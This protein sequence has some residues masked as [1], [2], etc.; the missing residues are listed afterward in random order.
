MSDALLVL[1][2]GSSSLKFSVFL[3]QDLPQPVVRGQIEGLTA[4]PRFV[5]RNDSAVISQKEWP[6]ETQLGHSG[7]IEFLFAWGRAGALSGHRIIAVGHR[8]VHGGTKFHAPVVINLVTLAELEALI[9]LA[10]LHQPHSVAAIRAVALM[11]PNLPQVACF[12][13]A[14]HRTY[15]PEQRPPRPAS[16]CPVRARIFS[17]R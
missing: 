1:N 10:P 15:Q 16:G 3:N 4:Q 12:D 9:P 5:A 17:M 7:A 13:T 2:A 6:P 14:F 11:A 8:V